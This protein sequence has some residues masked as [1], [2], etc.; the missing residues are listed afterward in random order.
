MWEKSL[1]SRCND[2][3]MLDFDHPVLK[4]RSAHIPTYNIRRSLLRAAVRSPLGLI[5][6][7]RCV[8]MFCQRKNKKRKHALAVAVE[9]RKTCLVYYCV[10]QE[11]EE[12]LSLENLDTTGLPLPIKNAQGNFQIRSQRER[13][14]RHTAST[15]VHTHARLRH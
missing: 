10:H 4:W 8:M 1:K 6:R 5:Y 14:Q 2:N 13:K 11:D 12:W 9:R 15:R 3:R 7:R